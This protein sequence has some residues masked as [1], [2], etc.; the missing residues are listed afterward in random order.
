MHPLERPYVTAQTLYPPR[1]PTAG[2]SLA[3]TSRFFPIQ[4][5]DLRDVVQELPLNGDAVPFLLGWRWLHVPGHAPGQIA[6]FRDADRTLLGA[7][8]FA[9]TVH[10]SKPAVLLGV[11][12]N[13]SRRHAV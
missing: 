2:G 1:D 6:L 13:Q 8:A 12:Q 3:F 4:L 10:G 7:D 11:V 9:T 5:P